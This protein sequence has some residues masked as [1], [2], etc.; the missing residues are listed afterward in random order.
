M[1]TLQKFNTGSIEKIQVRTGAITSFLR[2]KKIGVFPLSRPT[3]IF[4]ADPVV[5]IA[6]LKETL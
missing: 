4:C 6:I 2:P 5:L 1:Q 3:L